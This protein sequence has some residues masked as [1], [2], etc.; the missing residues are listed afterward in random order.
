MN[1]K[2][3]ISLFSFL[4]IVF[5][6]AQENYMLGGLLP[7]S[8]SFSPL[9]TEK[10]IESK[11]AVNTSVI[12]TEGIAP[13]GN[14]ASLGSCTCWALGYYYKTFQEWQERGWD[15]TDS[16]HQFSPS[17]LYNQLNGG[18]NYGSFV[19]DVL[20]MIEKYGVCTM[21]DMPYTTNYTVY[22][23]RSDYLN[24]MNYRSQT[25]HYTLLGDLTQLKQ[26]ISN[27][28]IAVFHIYV[29]DNFYSISSSQQFYAVSL[30]SG[31]NHGGHVVTVIGFDDSIITPDGYGAFRCVNSWGTTWG[32]K[33]YWWITYQAIK[34]TTYVPVQRFWWSEDRVDYHPTI[35]AEIDVTHSK[36]DCIDL[37]LFS[38]NEADP[39]NAVQLN[40]WYMDGYRTGYPSTFLDYAFPSN[41]ILY[42]ISDFVLNRPDSLFFFMEDT[43]SD[44]QSGYLN[45]FTAIRLTGEEY[46]ATDTPIEIFDFDYNVSGLFL[47]SLNSSGSHEESL[48]YPSIPVK[49]S[50]TGLFY[51]YRNKILR[52]FPASGKC[53]KI[54]I[55]DIAGRVIIENAMV[56]GNSNGFYLNLNSLLKPGNYFIKSSDN[57]ILKISIVR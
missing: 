27:G 44:S 17:F 30:Q 12:I 8:M 50:K 18:A 9:V 54:S 32:D 4:L 57:L 14:Q 26:H 37:A 31:T 52:I 41:S 16:S 23:D 33:G 3:F 34:Y 47:D 38:N 51:N 40:S 6:S 48:I 53:P 46:A 49:T 24:S 36:R 7:D 10:K 20:L 35:Y 43:L 55:L 29:Y 56:R 13:V 21:S 1:K 45:S 11:T 22:P 25:S 19:D 28:E 2:L 15:I 5:A 42:D 39:Q